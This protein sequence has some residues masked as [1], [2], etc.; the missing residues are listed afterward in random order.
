MFKTCNLVNNALIS[1]VGGE[2][3]KAIKLQQSTSVRLSQGPDRNS[4]PAD[5]NLMN[6][7]SE[8]YLNK[9]T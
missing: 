2:K 9:I 7:E 8:F 6:S 4:G 5:K 3:L 1:T